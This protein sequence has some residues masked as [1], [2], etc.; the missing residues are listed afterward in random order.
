MRLALEEPAASAWEDLDDSELSGRLGALL[1]GAR[2]ALM[3]VDGRSGSGKST[4]AERAARLV[5]GT[6][7]HTDDVA[8]HH[9]M[10]DWSDILIDGV[11]TP[12][13]RGDEVSF[14]PPGWV[15]RGRVG[16][17][18]VPR[19]PV[20]VIEGV[21]AGR[22]DLAVLADLV[23]WVQSDSAEARRRGLERDVEL[24]RSPEEAEEFWD[25]WMRDEEPFH[26][27]DRPW[28]RAALIVNGTPCG[29]SP[30]RTLLAPG[31]LRG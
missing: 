29:G 28:S 4:F 26:A 30:D 19:S 6:V 5:G 2:R 8:W 11:I 16:A 20:L 12:W 27:A 7:V 23:V 1:P 3:L 25:S 22:A 15:A 18:E 13:R 14:R 17:V 10:L 24:G 9:D 21:G 31:P